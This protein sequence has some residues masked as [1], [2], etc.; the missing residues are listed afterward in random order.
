MKELSLEEWVKLNEFLGGLLIVV[1]K[2]IKGKTIGP[3][4]IASFQKLIFEEA[5][6]EL[7]EFLA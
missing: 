6:K 2:I 1:G 7:N 3:E 4:T 5:M